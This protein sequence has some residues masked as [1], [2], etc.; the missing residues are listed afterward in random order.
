MSNEDSLT[1]FFKL[2]DTG[3]P[4]FFLQLG[5][6]ISLFLDKV[7]KQ[8]ALTNGIEN[9]F[10]LTDTNFHL[11]TGYN[12]IDISQFAYGSKDFDG[13]YKHHSTNPYFFEKSCFD[14]WFMINAMA[15]ALNIS[16][17]CYADCDVLIMEDLKPIHQRIL[18]EGYE[19]ST[20][21]FEGEDGRSVT[22]AHTSF[23]SSKLLDDFCQFVIL[24][25]ADQQAFDIILK[26]TLAG[27]FLNNTNLSD[28][29]LLDVFRTERKPN[30]LNLLTLEDNNICFDFNAGV[31]FNGRKHS[32]V[33]NPVHHIKKL[34]RRGGGLFGKV[35]GANAD[36]LYCRFYTV[37]FQGYV[38]KTLIPLYV[39]TLSKKEAIQNRII[40][41]Y[42]FALRKLKLL[43]NE[44]KRRA[45]TLV[46][47]P[48]FI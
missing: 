47:K 22:S 8:A 15:K 45:K 35:K 12:C 14:R 48:N 6:R 34:V 30:V 11:Y 1:P 18:R 26:D 16:H 28:M 4:I 17:F 27:K 29:I 38:T 46:T 31:S 7:L 36:I 40:G 23:W 44:L 9:V 39:T 32:F 2:P 41:E 24:K 33:I 25:Y 43:K 19:G 37:H 42:N 13:L 21:Y 5:S 10:V 20:M 3:L